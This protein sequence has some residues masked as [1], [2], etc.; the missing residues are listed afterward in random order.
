MSARAAV[1]LCLLWFSTAVA[2]DAARSYK[3]GLDAYKAGNWSGV[4]TAMLDAIADKPEDKRTIL[5]GTIPVN[6]VPHAYLGI[7][8]ANLGNCAA[9]Q[10]ALAATSATLLVKE[11]LSSVVDKAQSKC[12][13]GVASNPP[14]TTTTTK[15]PVASNPPPTTTTTKPPVSTPPPVSTNK[16]P[17]ATVPPAVADAAALARAREN[18]RNAIA[19]ATAAVQK[20]QAAG[21]TALELSKL[22][23][24]IDN[25]KRNTTTQASEVGALNNALTQA[26]K[27]LENV[28]AAQANEAARVQTAQRDL[29]ALI[30]T[31]TKL[32]VEPSPNLKPLQVSLQNA[33][34]EARTAQVG[35][36][37]GRL[38]IALANLNKALA[39]LNQASAQLRLLAAA[40]SKLMPLLQ[41]YLQGR[42]ANIANAAWVDES[43]EKPGLAQAYLLRAAA[44]YQLYLL[45]AGRD[46]A[47]LGNA[48]NDAKMARKLGA[49][50]PA[51]PFFSPRFLSWYANG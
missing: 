9:A 44:R 43:F 29:L 28:L 24:L 21:T 34:A 48:Q 2:A 17:I 25:A 12:A 47:L 27:R 41:D 38:Q 15:L 39:A 30:N 42:F 18:L 35:Q 14:P 22:Q 20:A 51:G 26:V 13:G 40:R 32:P 23:Q 36:D 31:A 33:L 3:T 1:I 10:R 46:A 4:R 8:E 16:P 11:N 19:V 45:S 7:A 5:Y 49:K 6:Y 50:L 37:V